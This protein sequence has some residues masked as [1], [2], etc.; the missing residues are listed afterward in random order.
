[1]HDSARASVCYVARDLQTLLTAVPG[2]DVMREMAGQWNGTIAPFASLWMMQMLSIA[3]EG[4]LVSHEFQ[5]G[6]QHVLQSLVMVLFHGIVV[7]LYQ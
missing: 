2:P 5:V 6:M 3:L 1:M 7:C 4:G